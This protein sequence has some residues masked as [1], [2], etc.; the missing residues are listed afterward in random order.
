MA[1]LR[2][3]SPVIGDPNAPWFENSPDYKPSDRLR[4]LAAA[5]VVAVLI[6]PMKIGGKLSGLLSI[7]SR[8][9]CLFEPSEVR[10]SQALA[11]QAMLAVQLMNFSRH[12]RISAVMNERERLA[13]NLHDTLAQGFTGVIVQLEAA[14]DA[15]LRGFNG[16]A[17][18]HA[19]RAS[20]LARESLQ[21]AR[22]V[23]RALRPQALEENNLCDALII[24]LEKMTAGTPMKST[25]KVE[26]V[27]RDLPADL[28][29][30]LLR[31]C[32]EVLTNSLRHAGASNFEVRIRFG[33]VRVD[34]DLIDGGR[35]F[36]MMTPSEGYGLVGIRERVEMTGGEMDLFSAP[37]AGTSVNIHFAVPY[38]SEETME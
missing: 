34:I 26:G 27:P 24:L 1:K 14:E 33:D 36:D 30:N 10:L 3:S 17:D 28:E 23:V 13:R 21:E 19:I 5:G 32:Q 16:E 31:I 37:G 38:G 12:S 35:G 4:K 2:C 29:E 20:E 22:R 11:Y 15:R 6:V 18:E 7:R 8:H 9:P 25:L